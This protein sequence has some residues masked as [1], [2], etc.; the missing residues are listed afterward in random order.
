MTEEEPQKIVWIGGYPFID[1]VNAPPGTVS[2]NPVEQQLLDDVQW[3]AQQKAQGLKG[4][5]LFQ[6]LLKRI[7]G[8]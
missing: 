4:W 5:A 3:E 7:G 6:A 1:G 8:K 2:E